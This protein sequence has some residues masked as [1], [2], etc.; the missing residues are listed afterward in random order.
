VDELAMRL[1]S[2]FKENDINEVLALTRPA[3]AEVAAAGE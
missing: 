2:V 1:G 3:P